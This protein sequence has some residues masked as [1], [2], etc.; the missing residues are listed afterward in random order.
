MHL[1]PKF[2]VFFIF[3]LILKSLWDSSLKFYPTIMLARKKFSLKLTRFVLWTIRTISGWALFKLARF[4][5]QQKNGPKMKPY[6]NLL[7]F[8]EFKPEMSRPIGKLTSQQKQ[9]K[10]FFSSLRFR[11]HLSQQ[12]WKGVKTKVCSH[13]KR[14]VPSSNGKDI[15]GK[16]RVKRHKNAFNRRNKRKKRKFNLVIIMLDSI[17]KMLHQNKE[18]TF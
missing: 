1:E 8:L 2:G 12:K 9:Q 4:Q 5:F 16:K 18:R 15:W 6:L 14:Q 13:W 10:C 7:P 3:A 17:F 11:H